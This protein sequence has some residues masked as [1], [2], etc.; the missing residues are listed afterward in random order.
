M[1]RLVSKIGTALLAGALLCG[2]FAGCGGS[3][4][5]GSS[6]AASS[7][8]GSSA[9]ASS[10]A[11]SSAAGSGAAGKT[12]TVAA[13]PTPH[14]EVLAK[15]KEILAKDGITLDIK[16]FTDYVQPNNVVDAGEIDCNYFQHKPYLDDFNEKNKTKLVSVAAIH[17]EPL[18]IYAGKTKAL[19]DLKDGATIA[20]PNDSTNEARALLLLE[21]NGI[22]KLKE[23]AGVSATVQDIAENKKNIKIMEFAA[24]QVSRHMDEVDLVVLNGNYALNAGLNASKDALV[25]EAADSEA[26][27]TYAN[28][29]VVK[30]GNEKN[31][32]IQA[33][34]KVLKSDE[35][36]KYINDTYKG[37]V[38]PM[39]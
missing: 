22:I 15:A 9:A 8:A 36:K 24:E 29:I 35:I 12:I 23:G 13:T 1:K 39:D 33:L 14:G 19:A 4:G 32:A 7:A 11:A 20:V 21:A 26:A 27:K 37:A 25:I 31:E 10:A 16:E 28:I 2:A 17:Y 34:C 3:T 38:V 18:G 5:S 6:A 30:E